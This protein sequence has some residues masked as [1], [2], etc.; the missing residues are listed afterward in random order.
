MALERRRIL[1]SYFPLR[2]A[3]ERLFESSFIVPQGLTGQMEF[4][5]AT[6][7]ATDNHVVVKLAV[8][9]VMPDDLA[10][11]VTGESVSIRGEVK[12]EQHEQKAQTY[13]DE[14]YQGRFQR[15]FTLPFPVDA[16]KATATVENGMLTLTL[17]K[18]EAV[19][20]KRIPV[21]ERRPLEGQAQ[22]TEGQAQQETV[23]YHLG[24]AR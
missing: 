14:L 18:S 21:S 19:K 6:V 9:G 15:S 12:R 8:P 17:P 10:I 3:M 5:T 2:D 24:H 20:P 7:H 13:I 22:Q 16:D 11:S 1:S 4:P 23:P